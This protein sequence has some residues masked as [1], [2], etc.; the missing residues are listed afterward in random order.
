SSLH[1]W[2]IEA[3]ST[4]QSSPGGHD[5]RPDSLPMPSRLLELVPVFCP[6]IPSASMLLYLSR[7]SGPAESTRACRHMPKRS[8]FRRLDDFVDAFQMI[9]HTYMNDRMAFFDCQPCRLG[10]F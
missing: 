10:G 2:L 1:P 3:P 6:L 8:S 9:I 5:A 7:R 4:A